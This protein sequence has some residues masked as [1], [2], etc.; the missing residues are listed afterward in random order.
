MERGTSEAVHPMGS[1]LLN[2]RGFAK[3]CFV[4]DDIALLATRLKLHELLP[5]G[6]DCD[7]NDDGLT[8]I[9]KYF[10]GINEIIEAISQEKTRHLVQTSFYDLLGG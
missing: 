3:K 2:E 1:I 8:A 7:M 5:H 6:N 4:Q 9:I 10:Y